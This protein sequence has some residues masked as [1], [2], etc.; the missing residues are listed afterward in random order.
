MSH[1]NNMI[2]SPEVTKVHYT[3]FDSKKL[4][5]TCIDWISKVGDPHN[6]SDF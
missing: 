6:W 1:I 5:D 3:C 2:L 4:P